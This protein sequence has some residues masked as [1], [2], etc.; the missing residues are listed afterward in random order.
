MSADHADDGDSVPVSRDLE[1][2]PRPVLVDRRVGSGLGLQ[3]H[4]TRLAFTSGPNT[5]EA[6]TA[7]SKVREFVPG[8]PRVTGGWT[9]TSQTYQ[10]SCSVV[11][12]SRHR[13]P[14]IDPLSDGS[15]GS[16]DQVVVRAVWVEK[17]RADGGFDE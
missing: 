17:R 16:V 12:Q 6:P 4:R 11:S 14:L 13:R 7:G 9:Q 15:L 3:H 10:P 2:V 5:A 1:G 8:R